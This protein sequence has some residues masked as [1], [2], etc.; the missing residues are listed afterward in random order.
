MTVLLL[1]N[2]RNDG[3][4]SMQRY[5]DLLRRLLVGQGV[6]VE[7]IRPEPVLGRLKPS[8]EGLGKW[9][10]Y[11]DKFVLFPF[12]LRRH[13][14]RKKVE[15]VSGYPFLVH[16]CDHSNAMYTRWLRDVPHVVTCHDVLAIQ[17]AL[18]LIPGRKTGWAG[19]LLQR[20]ILSGLKRAKRIICVSPETEIDLI[21]LAPELKEK[22]G[23][24]D[25]VLNYPYEPLPPEQARRILSGL[26]VEGA[27]DPVA[28]RFL[29]HVGG[30]QWYKNRE[31]VIRILGCLYKSYPQLTGKG[32]LKLVLAGK[33]P[34]E[35]LR[36]LVEEE[37]VSGQ[38]IFAS[39][40]TNEQL[41][42]LY[43]LAEILV[44]P[45][46]KEGFGWP[47]IEAQA[48]GCP[49]VT[50]DLPPMNRLAGPAGLLANPQDPADFAAKVA[51]LLL[52]AP[53]DRLGRKEDVVHYAAQFEPQVFIEQILYTYKIFLKI[54]LPSRN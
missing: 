36:R 10:G 30:N 52:E 20:W 5:A 46:L 53:L 33:A 13:L 47:L 44:Y 39:S 7:V 23:T 38:V 29:F 54:R 14:R 34:S 1:E 31:A 40:P 45:S 42:A 9:L 11:F 6:D 8:G 3:H 15:F 24:I 37:K 18:G 43:T 48:C 50:S 12:V 32:A 41:G 35:N 2:Y 17:S 4:E 25:N 49:V 26:E 27:F 19:Q 21:T 22:T 16:I 51:F 28:D